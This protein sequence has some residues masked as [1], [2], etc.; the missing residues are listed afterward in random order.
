MRDAQ[1]ITRPLSG[2][3]RRASIG[4][5][6]I[7]ALRMLGLFMILPVFSL[8]AEE[9]DGATPVLTGLAIS[10]YG[11]TQSL[12]QIPFGMLSDRYGR[13]RIITIGLLLFAA[14]SVLAALSD[15][16]YGIIAGRALQGCGAIA[17]AVMALAADLTREQQRT[18]AM[19]LIGMSIGAAF[20]V[21]LVVGPI[22]AAWSGLEGIFWLTAILAILGILVLFSVVPTPVRHGFH[23]DTQPVPAQFKRVLADREL[24]R[25]DGGIFFLHLMLTAMF[26]VFPLALRD[27]VVAV[28]DHWSIYLPALLLSMLVAV[29][30]VIVGEKQRKMKPVF[31]I[32]IGLTAVG[33]LGMWGS[34]NQLLWLSVFLFVFFS[35]FNLLEATLPSLISKTAPP[36]LKGTA[37]GVYS[38]SQFLGAFAGGVFGGW[39]YGASGT[40][41]VFLFAAGVAIVWLTVAATM[42]PPNHVSSL[43]INIGNLEK[44]E[45]IRLSERIQR[46]KGVAEAVIVPEDGIAFLKVDN[47]SLDRDELNRLIPNIAN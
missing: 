41:S 21:S 46:I 34:N 23:R 26:V 8:F 7:F 3:E 40:S 35:G 44:A 38:T 18:K 29:P 9:I 45:A 42:S 36:G 2:A 30:L 24:I 10:A 14:G 6:A 32:A 5:A 1:D 27:T 11:L 17:A 37:I 22:I 31:L 13:K 28:D 47:D 12:L 15:S 25:L 4:L 33:N 39:L 43:M 16:I 20:A 19:A